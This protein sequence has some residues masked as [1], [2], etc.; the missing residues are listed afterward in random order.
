MASR[1]KDEQIAKLIADYALMGSYHAVAKQNGV[2]ENT[3]KKY[4]QNSG[5]AEF[6]DLCKR[7]KEDIKA[8]LGA[9]MD[10][11]R[12]RVCE[13]IGLALEVLPD[14]IQNAKTATEVTTALGTLIDKWA[15]KGTATGGQDSR[16]DDPITQA[17]RGKYGDAV[18]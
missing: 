16:E 7:K 14:K 15:P 2:S 6:A 17:L 18:R 3:V 8:D 12:D 10:A 13:I 11:N 9:Y 1:L 5:V 4:V